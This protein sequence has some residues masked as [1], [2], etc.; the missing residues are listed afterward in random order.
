VVPAVHSLSKVGSQVIFATTRERWDVMLFMAW[1]VGM[2]KIGTQKY[3]AQQRKD[4]AKILA[5]HPPN[6]V[7]REYNK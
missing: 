1:M 3:H 4:V 5:A 6:T 7:E 2:A